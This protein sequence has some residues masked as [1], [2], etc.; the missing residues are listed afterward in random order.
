MSNTFGKVSAIFT[1]GGLVVCMGGDK[2]I[3][4][5]LNRF[6]PP[7]Q[8]IR[9]TVSLADDPECIAADEKRR[10]AFARQRERNAAV[11]RGDQPAQPTRPF[12]SLAD[13]PKYQAAKA[14]TNRAIRK[15]GGHEIP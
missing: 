5:M 1:I 10:D 12:V 6:K 8:P 4:K 9:P 3:A 14:R 15:L 2:L 7:A 11:A 13:D